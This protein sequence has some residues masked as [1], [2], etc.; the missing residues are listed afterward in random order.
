[1]RRVWKHPS[2]FHLAVWSDSTL[3]GL[4]VG[5]VSD[6]NREG[7]R[8]SISVDF[9][10]SAHDPAHPLRGLIAP[11]VIDAADTYGRALDA[12]CLRLMQPLEGVLPLYESLGF[13]TVWQ[14]G[15]AL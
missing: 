10:E 14:Q 12:R 9:I 3:C 2:G 5:R 13:T 6:R 1:M 7:G 15:R 4:A 8:N 11:L